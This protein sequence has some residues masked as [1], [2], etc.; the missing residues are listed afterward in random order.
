M[1]NQRWARRRWWMLSNESLLNTTDFEYYLEAGCTSQNLSFTTY[2]SFPPF[3]V[4]VIFFEIPLAFT[5]VEQRDTTISG[6]LPSCTS[7]KVT[8]KMWKR[9]VLPVL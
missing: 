1:Y 8:E 6:L 7:L 3:A 4:S 9:F 2:V 5:N